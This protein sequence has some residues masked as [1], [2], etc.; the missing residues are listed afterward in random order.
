VAI[1]TKELQLSVICL[2]SPFILKETQAYCKLDCNK[3]KYTICYLIIA[4]SSTAILGS[5][6]YASEESPYD[7][8]YDHGCDDVRISDP[9][10]RYINPDG[11]GSENHTDRFMDGYHYGFAACSGNVPN[12]RGTTDLSS[13]SASSAESNNENNNENSMSQSRETKII[14]CDNGKCNPQ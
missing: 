2:F 7:S 13:S 4:L 8:G 9:D 14:I 3:F 6:A 5:S 11:K 10:D 1:I 12:V